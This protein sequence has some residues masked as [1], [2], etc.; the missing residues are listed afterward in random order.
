M[1]RRARWL[2]ETRNS[3]IFEGLIAADPLKTTALGV[4]L[5]LSFPEIT[6]L[7]SG[8]SQSAISRFA[9][10]SFDDKCLWVIDRLEACPTR[11]Q[12]DENESIRDNLAVYDSRFVL[13]ISCACL[14]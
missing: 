4:C 8:I 13:V 2:A 6:Y 7:Q 1:K 10:S 14:G 3:A 12:W 5:L 9:M 11:K